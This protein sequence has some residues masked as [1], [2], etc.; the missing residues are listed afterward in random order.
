[1]KTLTIINPATGASI[2]EL[3]VDEPAA[4]AAKAQA[5]RRPNASR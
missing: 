5:A 4:I 1:M 3:A 2:G